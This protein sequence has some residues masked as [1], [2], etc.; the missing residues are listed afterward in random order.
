MY[1]TK[2]IHKHINPNYPQTYNSIGDPYK[3]SLESLPD[4]WKQK[5]FV[6]QKFPKNADNGFFVK[7]AYHPEPYIEI[8]EKYSQ[9]QPLEKRKLGFG[10]HD[11]SKTGE[12]TCSKSTERFRSLVKHEKRLM[13]KHRIQAKEKELLEMMKRVSVKSPKDRYGKKLHSTR[14]LYDVGRSSVT[15]YNPNSARDSFYNLPKHAK[16]ETEWGGKDPIRRLGSHRPS[17]ATI[18]EYAWKHKHGKP[19]HGVINGVQKFYDRGHLECK[20]F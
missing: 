11:A 6:T 2:S 1:S 16:V 20:G 7:Q 13:D 8:A 17:S 9:T 12:F 3:G 5:Q 10:S 19:E 4:R 14:F 18:G 15:E